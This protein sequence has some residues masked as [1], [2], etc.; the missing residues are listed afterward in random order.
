MSTMDG[1]FVMP[2]ELPLREVPNLDGYDDEFNELKKL[3]VAVV[4]C[5]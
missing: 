2:Q 1:E 3:I 5:S 4:S